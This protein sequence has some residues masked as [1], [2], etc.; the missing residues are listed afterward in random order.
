MSQSEKTKTTT[1]EQESQGPDP[2][3]PPGEK[4][5]GE[6]GLGPSKPG[7]RSQGPDPADPPEPKIDRNL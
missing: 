7:T 3:K 1:V 4:V 2:R 5:E 6:R